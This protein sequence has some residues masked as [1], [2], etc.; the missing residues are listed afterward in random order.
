M[1]DGG[2]KCAE[3][4]LLRQRLCRRVHM[5]SIVAVSLFH[6]S[7]IA[8]LLLFPAACNYGG[9]INKTHGKHR[10]K[11]TNTKI[12]R[13]KKEAWQQGWMAGRLFLGSHGTCLAAHPSWLGLAPALNARTLR[14]RTS[15]V[16]KTSLLDMQDRSPRHCL[17]CCVRGGFT[18]L[19]PLS[20]PPP[21]PCTFPRKQKA[22]Q[23]LRRQVH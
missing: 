14:R 9:A 11:D 2:T 23:R 12:R 16:L 19:L 21:H 10:P 3:E 8:G 17:S 7:C 22:P 6:R 18:L 15:T 20:R 13:G 1:A 4:C 5:L